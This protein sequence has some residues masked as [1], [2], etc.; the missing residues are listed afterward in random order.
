MSEKVENKNPY[1]QEISEAKPQSY[2]TY[3]KKQ[4]RKN[5]RALISFYFV[6]VL[7]FVALFAD[8]LANNKPLY[9]QIEDETYFPVFQEYA[10]DLGLRQWD[11]ALLN[12]EWKDVD[13]Q[14]VIWPLIPYLPSDMDLMNANFV[15]PFDDQMVDSAKWTHWMGTDNIGRDVLSGMIHGTRV[16][17]LVGIISMSI[18]T[19]IGI[20][21][22]GLAGYFG[23]DKLKLPRIQVWFL[24]LGVVFAFFWAFFARSYELGEA[25][26]DG[27]FALF[28]QL[29]ISFI[30][31]VLVLAIF[32]FLAFPFTKIPFLRDPI[33]APIDMIVTRVIEI[34]VSV[35]RLILILS[36]IA[37][38]KPSIFLIMIVIGFTSWTGIA[39][40]IRAEM[41]KVRKLEFM[42]AAQSFG[43]SH[44]RAMV[45]HAI[46]NS[47]NPVFIAIAFGIASS[48]LIESTLSFLGIGV[49]PEEVTWGAL[50]SLGRKA[51]DAW[52]I[53]TFPGFAIFLMVTLFNL[54]GEG[55]TDALDPRQ[56]K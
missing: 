45:K 21:L 47:L 50:L 4:F 42:E 8:I 46:P 27:I 34:V 52:W 54:I 41:L 18:A 33:A 48:I 7:A 44:L 6:A 53:V 14:S 56:K 19:F 12:I 1:S 22:G 23:D 36:I 37:V 29:F 55:L 38:A 15:G 11:E 35:P 26:S 51:P 10:V 13:Y 17:F 30:I 40:F 43:Y 16:A 24:Y 5:K 20:L 28:F 3:V 39:R 9:C 49:P 31:F 32:F 2:L 25:F